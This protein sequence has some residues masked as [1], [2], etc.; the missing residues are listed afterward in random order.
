MDPVAADQAFTWTAAA[1]L[2]RAPQAER[3]VDHVGEAVARACAGL[4]PR[5]A[6]YRVQEDRLRGAIRGRRYHIRRGS[7]VG[8]VSVQLF[9]CSTT[10]RRNVGGPLRLRVDGRMLLRPPPPAPELPLAAIGL[11]LILLAAAAL[12]LGLAS[13]SWVEITRA[14]SLSPFV[15]GLGVLAAAGLVL[16]ALAT[17]ESVIRQGAALPWDRMKAEL[18][19]WMR[20]PWSRDADR[21]RWVTLREDLEQRLGSAS[22]SFAVETAGPCR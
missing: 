17:T 4:F 12:L 7:F 1:A 19:A 16:I 11:G 5:W 8:Q 10:Y 21:R 6:G 15:D 9:A 20:W 18:R 3:D 14:P 22:G 13:F 2:S